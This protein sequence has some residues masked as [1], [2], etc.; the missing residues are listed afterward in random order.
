VHG[1]QFARIWISSVTTL[2]HVKSAW[3]Q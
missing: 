1:S 2:F 3:S